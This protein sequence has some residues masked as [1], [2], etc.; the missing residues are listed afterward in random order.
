MAVLL[1][2]GA[3][4]ALAE[5]GEDVFQ[6]P[7]G[8]EK[9]GRFRDIC[10]RLS[11]HPVIKGN[12]EQE[13]IISS[14]HRSLVSRGNFIIAADLGMV[15]ETLKPFPSTLVTGRDYLVQSRPG[16]QKTRLDAR[17]NE[18][19]LRLADVI[20]SVFSGNYRGLQ[21]NFEIFFSESTGAWELGLIPLDVSIR[22]FAA[23][24]SMAGDTAIRFIRI[25][26][27]NGDTIRYSLSNQ[28]Y[29]PAL[30]VN[31]KAFFSFP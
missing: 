31:E 7:L 12:F 30:S 10:I 14:L 4:F 11:E 8:P 26:E 23:R 15:W 22:N 16:G 24:I 18:T 9:I 28:S 13:K 1:C 21:D 29:P 19:F 3:V 6:H 2:A 17:G 25:R 27:Q 20:S 5:E